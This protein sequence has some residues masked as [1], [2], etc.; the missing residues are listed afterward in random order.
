MNDKHELGIL[1][2]VFLKRVKW[3]TREYHPAN[4]RDFTN[5]GSA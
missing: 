4:D 5:I 3:Q 1:K 2:L